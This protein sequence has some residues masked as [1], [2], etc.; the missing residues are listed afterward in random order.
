MIEQLLG[1]F[2]NGNSANR[3]TCNDCGASLRYE[4]LTSGGVYGSECVHAHIHKPDWM[5]L[6][7]KHDA[8]KWR[9]I[10]NTLNALVAELGD[11][12]I[13]KYTEYRDGSKSVA[14]FWA[15]GPSE[16]RDIF[17]DKLISA[18]WIRSDPEPWLAG[19]KRY[20]LTRPK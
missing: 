17:I 6:K 10:Q 9:G 19:S 18:G 5:T 11:R 12:G 13:V 15:Y 1:I 4:Y 14:G 20:T 8:D 7:A 2:D 16:A 3:G